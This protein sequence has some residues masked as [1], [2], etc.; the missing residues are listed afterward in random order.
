MNTYVTH[1]TSPHVDR[2]GTLAA[3]FDAMKRL[4]G[5]L[6]PG[7]LGLPL[8]PLSSRGPLLCPPQAMRHL[9]WGRSLCRGYA[10]SRARPGDAG[11]RWMATTPTGGGAKGGV[12]PAGQNPYITM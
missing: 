7:A 10:V 8:W 5:L 6:R 4:M 3:P 1:H 2:S 11:V 12:K 9:Q